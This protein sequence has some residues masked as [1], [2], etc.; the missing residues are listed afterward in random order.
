MHKPVR[1]TRWLL[2][3]AA[4]FSTASMGCGGIDG[5]VLSYERY[6]QGT[7]SFS[8]LEVY[9]NIATKEERDTDHVALLWSRRNSLILDAKPRF[10]SRFFFERHGKHSYSELRIA[11]RP[12]GQ[13]ERF[14]TTVDLDTIQVIPGEFFLNEYGALCC[15]QQVEIPGATVDAAL[16]EMIPAVAGYLSELAGEEIERLGSGEFE[17]QTWD[18]VR[19]KLLIWLGEHEPDP[20]DKAEEIRTGPLDRDSLRL[21]IKSGMDRTLPL[22][23]KADALTLVIP[24]SARDC[25][26]AVTTMN[27]ARTVVAER[28]KAG[29][30]VTEELAPW[31]DAVA[32]RHIPESGLSVTLN[33][34]AYWK[35]RTR[36]Q[37]TM[38]AADTD[39]ARAYE[40]TVAAIRARGIEVN[41]ADLFPLI[42]KRFTAE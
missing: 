11:P 27:L 8:G 35:A 32:F 31:L 33:L 41:N 26:E 13:A 36:A 24:L 7:D 22:T 1:R 34:G 14:T 38:P 17:Q 4:V 40:D 30:A 12:E 5:Q 21:L 9:A 25:D 23:R 42:L 10:G 28:R 18:D 20:D 29:K 15:Y 2:L 37:H 19:K 39:Q 3:V 16:R 6:N